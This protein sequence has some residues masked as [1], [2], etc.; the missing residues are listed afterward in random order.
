[1]PHK[2][3]KRLLREEQ[4]KQKGTNLAPSKESLDNEGIPKS[5]SRVLNASQ[6]RDTYKK[7]RKL[8]EEGRDAKREK[9]RRMDDMQL[10]IKPGEPIHHFYKR[11]EDDMRPM[12]MSA[13]RS[14][15]AVER[16]AHKDALEAKAK[17]R[18]GAVSEGQES[19]EQ[20]PPLHAEPQRKDTKKDNSLERHKDFEK[21]STSAPRRLNDVAQAPPEIKKAPRGA[22]HSGLGG[23]REGVLSMAQKSM[24]EQEREKVINRYR[25]LKASRLKTSGG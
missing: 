1:M 9:R 3:A 6:I 7:K 25:M 2:K 13:V 12:V 15:K 14:S 11:V 17:E 18:R 22:S 10:K 16:K 19:R 21:Y 5:A 24:M 23:K 20:T 4:R 8:E